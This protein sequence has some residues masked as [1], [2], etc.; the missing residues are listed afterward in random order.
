MSSEKEE[1]FFYHPLEKQWLSCCVHS[2][3]GCW[4][5]ITNGSG[6]WPHPEWTWSLGRKTP[7]EVCVLAWGTPCATGACCNGV[8]V[9]ATDS[10]AGGGLEGARKDP[11]T[12]ES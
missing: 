1:A 2:W 7:P 6:L 12:A 10:G 11:A 3:A 4:G 5:F 9:A 8:R